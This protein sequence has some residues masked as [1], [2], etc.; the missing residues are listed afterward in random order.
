MLDL[1]HRVYEADESFR[2]LNF[3]VH[4]RLYFSQIVLQIAS[5]RGADLSAGNRSGRE[6]T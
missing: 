5:G 2:T 1:I 4:T 6:A 3:M